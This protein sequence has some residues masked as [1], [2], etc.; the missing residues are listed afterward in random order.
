MW[1][2][3]SSA[4]HWKKAL[5]SA[6]GNHQIDS[7][8]Q[9]PMFALALLLA[10][11]GQA[12]ADEDGAGFRVPGQFPS[13]AP[14]PRSK[15]SRFPSILTSMPGGRMA[16]W[17]A[18]GRQ[19]MPSRR[20]IWVSSSRRPTRVLRRFLGQRRA[21]RLRPILVG[22]NPLPTYFGEPRSRRKAR[23]WPAWVTSTPWRNCSGTRDLTTGWPM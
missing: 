1:S 22:T 7:Q 23:R 13:F 4:Q 20:S 14:A 16:I 12:L 18:R 6:P 5:V 21:F 9:A 10:S 2:M 17:A 11:S 15:V 8:V 19:A 3:P